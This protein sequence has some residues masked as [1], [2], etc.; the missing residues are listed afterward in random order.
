MAGAFVHLHLPPAPAPPRMVTTGDALRVYDSAQALECRAPD[1]PTPVTSTRRGA[2][3]SQP[4][5]VCTPKLR[6]RWHGMVRGCHRAPN[7]LL[8]AATAPSVL[9]LPSAQ[10]IM[11]HPDAISKSKRRSTES[12]L[13]NSPSSQFSTAHTDLVRGAVSALDGRHDIP[14]RGLV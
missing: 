13:Q 7:A 8:Q 1:H 6:P 11:F 5:V 14:H 3:S 10:Y 9:Q 2:F 4:R 12:A